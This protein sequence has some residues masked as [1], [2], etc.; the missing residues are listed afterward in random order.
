MSELNQ[1][2]WPTIVPEYVVSDLAASLHF[3]V[4]LLGFR[5]LYDR[6]EHRFSYLEREGGH[7]MLVEKREPDH[8]RGETWNGG[9]LDE[10]PFGR[11]V[12]IQVMAKDIRPIIEALQAARWPLYVEPADEWYRVGDTE[13]G[14]RQFMMQ[15]PDG[16]L[17]RFA[18]DL[19]ER[20]L[21]G[22]HLPRD[23]NA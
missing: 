1:V 10:K 22:N 23:Q 21:G 2:A 4:G 14:Q 19:G 5:V 12:H 6:P 20:D 15:D 8:P 17:I 16:Y 3:W 13:L 7:V 9:V 11:G 18:Q